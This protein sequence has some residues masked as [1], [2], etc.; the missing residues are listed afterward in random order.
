MHHHT[1]LLIPELLDYILSFMDRNDNVIN[2]CVCKQWSEIALDLIWW[3]VE[4]LLQLLALLRPYETRD[5]STV[6]HLVS[7]SLPEILCWIWLI[8]VG[9]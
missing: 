1:A 6:R 9:F 7:R 3:K 5:A 8:Y 2:A 4:R